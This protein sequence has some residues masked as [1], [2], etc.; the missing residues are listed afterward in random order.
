MKTKIIALLFASVLVSCGGSKKTIVYDQSRAPLSTNPFGQ[1]YDLPTFEADTEEFFAATGIAEG[2][3]SRMG[4]LQQAA[5][6][7]AQDLI[8]QKMKHAYKGMVSGYA[9]Y[10]GINTSTIAKTKMEQGGDQIIDAIINDTQAK[11]VKFSG[12]DEKGN[13]TC[14]VAVRIS[15]KE[16]A[17]KIAKG[18]SE[19][20]ELKLRF[21]EEKY[22]KYMRERFKEYKENQQ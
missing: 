12:V 21:Q 19:D 16:T 13:V 4:V 15:K 6:A 9:N 17:D 3:K 11:S 18:L 20:E 1:T 14:Y 8:R 7:N 2:A 5:L 10:M 22:R